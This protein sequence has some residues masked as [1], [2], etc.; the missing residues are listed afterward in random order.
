MGDIAYVVTYR[1]DGTA[2]RRANLVSVLNWLRT[3]SEVEII[4]IE[5][6]EAPSAACAAQEGMRWVFVYNPGPFN[7]SW[8]LNVGAR[9][10]TSALLAFGDADVICAPAWPQALRLLREQFPVVKPYRRIVDLSEQESVCVRAG[11]W[12]FQPQRAP[13]EAPNREAQGEFIV[14][15]GGLF[16]VRREVFDRVGGFDE[17]F[18]GWG[19]ED[20]AMTL[21]LIASS[22]PMHTL[23]LA[24]AMHL[25][26]P[27]S[28][29]TT[30]KQAQYLANCALL[31][32][33]RRYDRAQLVR[34]C[35]S[36]GPTLGNPE[37]YRN[38]Q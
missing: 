33:Y 9:L 38:A 18:L 13:D 25:W 15:A 34:R 5:Q 11:Q 19:G 21:R 17:A 12:D 10:T 6:D 7:K 27:R 24:P 26:H 29:A 8:G 2:Q 3:L 20:D 32:E 31:S 23:D 22:A 36:Q 28:P 30:F 4:V 35:E 1:D 14:F 16:L 37:K